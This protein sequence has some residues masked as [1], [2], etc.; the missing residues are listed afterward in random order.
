M[1]LLH[2]EVAAV[3]GLIGCLAWLAFRF[4]THRIGEK[5][6]A[7]ATIRIAG[8]ALLAGLMGAGVAGVF[9]T[10]GVIATLGASIASAAAAAAGLGG[11]AAGPLVGRLQAG[12]V[13]SF[14]ASAL[15]AWACA[16]AFTAVDAIVPSSEIRGWMA[17]LAWFAGNAPVAALVRTRY[18]TPHSAPIQR[19]AGIDD[20]IQREWED[21][22]RRKFEAKV[23]AVER[24]KAG[25]KEEVARHVA[26]VL[27]LESK[28]TTIAKTPRSEDLDQL[29]K[30]AEEVESRVRIA[31]EQLVEERRRFG[32][33]Q[34]DLERER[35]DALAMGQN[36]ESRVNEL[37][38]HVANLEDTI[39]RLAGGRGGEQQCLTADLLAAQARIREL[40]AVADDAAVRAS[41]AEAGLARVSGQNDAMAVGRDRLVRER[42]QLAARV[43]ELDREAKSSAAAQR[44][45]NAERDR[46]E[47][48]L[49]AVHDR[50][51]QAE[52]RAKA[53]EEQ[54]RVRASDLEREIEAM[55]EDVVRL[56]DEKTNAQLIGEEANKVAE[57]L[58]RQLE[59]SNDALE[60]EKKNWQSSFDTLRRESEA[61]KRELRSRIEALEAELKRGTARAESAGASAGRP[62]S[63]GEQSTGPAGAPRISTTSRPM[64]LCRGAERHIVKPPDVDCALCHFS[65]WASSV[66]DELTPLKCQ[67]CGWVF[68]ARDFSKYHWHCPECNVMLAGVAAAGR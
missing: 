37:N 62:G 64:K 11:A 21:E 59:Q 18:E 50:L 44:T 32:E 10:E 46:L 35:D 36:F 1:N 9:R 23:G 15:G 38:G 66:N 40:S 54:G 57:A 20:A 58:N 33:R 47:T 56:E 4:D 17:A 52:A 63:S 60:A 2:I 51:E 39:R 8:P 5:I 34:V 55:G 28:L 16:A 49:R 22:F 27:E 41:E 7:W 3:G 24:Q 61:E 68:H 31:E 14:T 26:R 65:K 67:K 48:E 13:S 29:R 43:E 12:L 30:T 42:D 19:S 25:L 6:D 53:A 45:V